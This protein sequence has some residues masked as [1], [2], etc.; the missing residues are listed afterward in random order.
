MREASSTNRNEM[1]HGLVNDMDTESE[2]MPNTIAV[3]M[4]SKFIKTQ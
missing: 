2:N 3:A 4:I 1:H